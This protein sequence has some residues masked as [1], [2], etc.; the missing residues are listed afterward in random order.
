M[1]AAFGPK[2]AGMAPRK[3]V[4]TAPGAL[5]ERGT[6]R[7]MSLVRK[8]SVARGVP[9]L[10]EDSWHR[11]NQ[12]ILA[13]RHNSSSLFGQRDHWRLRGGHSRLVNRFYGLPPCVAGLGI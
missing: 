9:E 4:C 1:P 10:A 2:A 12:L 5:R 11:N 7:E 8:M 3:A 13:G 6:P